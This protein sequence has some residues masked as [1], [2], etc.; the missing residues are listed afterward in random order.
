MASAANMLAGVGYGDG[1]AIQER[2]D[3]IY[4]QLVDHYGIYGGGYTDQALRWWLRSSHNVWPTNPYV[5]VNGYGSHYARPW[6]DPDVPQFLA[7][8]LRGC[9]VVG[10]GIWYG[11]LGHATTLWGDEIES[12]GPVTTN[13]A[14]AFTT[15]SDDPTDRV[16]WSRQYQ[17]DTTTDPAAPRWRLG[18]H[19]SAPMIS[20]A[21]TL[22]TDPDGVIARSGIKIPNFSG[23]TV[24]TLQFTAWQKESWVEVLAY[25]AGVNVSANPPSIVPDDWPQSD[26]KVH[27]IG[28]TF[29]GMDI[30]DGNWVT[31]E[32]EFI[33]S[34][35][36][37][38]RWKDVEL[39]TGGEDPFTPFRDHGW[40]V[41]SS[42]PVYQLDWVGPGGFV[43]GTF[44]IVNQDGQLLARERLIHQFNELVDPDYHL[45]MLE[46]DDAGSPMYVENIRFGY[47][48]C[49]LMGKELWTFDEW[50][51]EFDDTQVGPG[52]GVP[53][54]L[55]WN[56]P[57]PGDW[58][59]LPEPA[60]LILMCLGSIALLRR[61]R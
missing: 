13:P 42:K 5:R 14:H 7:N 60:S 10:L 35:W 33:L 6:S 46:N 20:Y 25:D 23:R 12:S 37:T 30:P 56:I 16:I 59:G 1:S 24:D 9:K 15:D 26:G 8:E 39:S 52:Q 3:G 29:D 38:I 11:S 28:A 32:V 57:G 44:D 27:S 51:S 43:V 48:D 55:F 41:D 4:G 50:L 53:F 49:D 34:D 40:T 61:R 45:V 19:S 47:S 22:S 17:Y 31:A 54:E 58:P 2:A 18:S 21:C 36:N